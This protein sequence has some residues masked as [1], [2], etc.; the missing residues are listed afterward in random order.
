MLIR[1]LII[2]QVMALSLGH[3]YAG[4]DHGGDNNETITP[5]SVM[6]S[7]PVHIGFD[8]A[9]SWGI[10][11]MDH[12]NMGHGSMNHDMG[13]D[14]NQDMGGDMN[15]DMDSDMD[16]DNDMSSSMDHS[17]SD[18][19][20]AV[21]PMIHLGFDR[22]KRVINLSKSKSNQIGFDNDSQGY[23]VVENR[24]I[25]YGGGLMIMGMPMNNSSIPNGGF[26]QVGLMPY[27][28]G[29][30]YRAR[31][32]NSRLEAKRSLNHMV[33]PKS[34]YDLKNWSIN[35][36]LSYSTTGGI[37]FSAGLGVTILSELSTGYMAQG[38]WI[39]SIAKASK[40]HVLVSIKK[41]NMKMFMSTLGMTFAALELHKFNNADRNFNFLFDLSK[42][43]ALDAYKK[44]IQ[45]NLVTA[46]TLAASE[47][48]GVKHVS[49]GVSHTTG[50]MRSRS[51]RIPVLYNNQSMS[52][53]TTTES[54][55]E[56]FMNKTSMNME[57]GMYM[58]TNKRSG[59]WSNHRDTGFIFMAGAHKITGEYTGAS[60]SV[61]GSFK[62]YFQNENTNT[63]YIKNRFTR[64]MNILGL[65][66]LDRI[67]LERYKNN[68][69]LK[70]V[71]AEI[72]I[73][74]NDDF[75]KKIMKLAQKRMFLSELTLRTEHSISKY[76]M[77][78]DKSR[79]LCRKRSRLIRCIDKIKRKTKKAVKRIPNAIRNMVKA[80]NQKDD[81][82]FVNSFTSLGQTMLTNRF[83]FQ[84]VFKMVGV[85]MPKAKLTIQGTRFSHSELTL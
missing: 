79:Q 77:N 37:M 63:A 10:G 43:Q 60:K 69:P 13:G 28:G 78:K 24:S 58:R 67:N 49:M 26:I 64:A 18:W 5:D 20:W 50:R 3:V 29:H 33:T 21:M 83:V 53:R 8:G 38:T 27:K 82:N 40:K 23:L 54:H 62:W 68:G 19:M 65:D 70:F 11:F 75:T 46:Q 74:L 66:D 25:Q 15:R 48:P 12:S 35:D 55:S 71:R 52:G 22:Y 76:F 6:L 81:K 45:G 39:T 16:H 72:D 80:Y 32:V 85:P 41:S 2:I 47:I 44:M 31:K 42:S 1:F 56:N 84:E 17:S 59:I 57:M 7:L 34:I 61:L 4:H 9:V 36:R 14:M 51:I 30:V 73:N